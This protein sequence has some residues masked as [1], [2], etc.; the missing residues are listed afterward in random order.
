MRV[1]AQDESFKSPFMFIYI[2][3]T[4]SLMEIAGFVENI[5]MTDS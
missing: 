4:Q 3:Y 2:A 5:C 1:L